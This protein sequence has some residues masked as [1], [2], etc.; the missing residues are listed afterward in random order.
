MYPFCRNWSRALL[1]VFIIA[2]LARGAFILMLQ[3]GFYFPDS[4]EYSAAAV[5]LITNGELGAAYSR[6]PGYP[7]FLAV[8]YALVGKSMFATRAVESVLGAFLALIVAIIGKRMGG[9]IV[10]ALA[11]MLWAIYPMGVFIA[12]LV[13]PENLLTM[14]LSLG[15]LCFLPPSHQDLSNK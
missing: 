6:P 3:D 2:L 10:G 1:F 14:L 11:G 7:A 4:T 5:N 12:G 15:M 9:E 8:I 13:Y